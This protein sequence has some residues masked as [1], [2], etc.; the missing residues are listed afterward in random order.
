LIR[1]AYR[2]FVSIL[3][4]VP[5][6]RIIEASVVF[7]LDLNEGRKEGRANVLERDSNCFWTID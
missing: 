2:Q 1:G 5:V 7:A 6:K 3:K 4:E